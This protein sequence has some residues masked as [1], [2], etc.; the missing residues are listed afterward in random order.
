MTR[1][2]D[3]EKTVEITMRKFDGTN[4]SPDMSND[5]FDAPL[6][7]GTD[8]TYKVDNVDDLIDYVNDW[9]EYREE[10]YDREALEEERENDKEN[11]LERIVDV[12]VL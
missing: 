4:L 1:F 9:A 8:E 10:C 5:I 2:T 3:G 7:E 6:S 12:V 11:G